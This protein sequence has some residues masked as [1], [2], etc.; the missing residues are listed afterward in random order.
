MILYDIVTEVERVMCDRE[1]HMLAVAVANA[2]R[3]AA[4]QDLYNK[5][6]AFRDKITPIY[7]RAQAARSRAADDYKAQSSAMA[8]SPF[9][10]DEADEQRRA[11]LDKAYWKADQ[12]VTTIEL[13]W[14]VVVEMFGTDTVN[15]ANDSRA[16]KDTK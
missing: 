16:A 11:E 12:E 13:Q 10:P 3:D 7:G 14:G 6:N 8:F 5:I 1:R 9:G 15:A 2:V 4:T